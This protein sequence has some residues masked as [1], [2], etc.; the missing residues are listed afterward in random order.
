M[1]TAADKNHSTKVIKGSHLR[2]GARPGTAEPLPKAMD[3]GA[4]GGLYAAVPLQTDIGL[5]TERLLL[6]NLHTHSRTLATVAHLQRRNLQ[7][8]SLWTKSESVPDGS[9]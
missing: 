9:A 4:D 8:D 3:D 6:L 7:S 5:S 2:W 1:G